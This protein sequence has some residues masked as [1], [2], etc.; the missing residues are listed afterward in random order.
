[1]APS[2]R[3]FGPLARKSKGMEKADVADTGNVVWVDIDD[4]AGQQ[5]IEE[6]LQPL[7]LRPSLVL[8][9]GQKGYWAYFKLDRLIPTQEIETLNQRLALAVGGD[10]AW[11]SNRI[12]RMPYSVHPATGAVA[13]L[14]DWTGSLYSPMAL[15]VLP[16][17]PLP[18]VGRPG[19]EAQEPIEP[20]DLDSTA[21]PLPKLSAPLWAYIRA[22]P[23]RKQGWDRSEVEQSIFYALVQQE[24][25]DKQIVA[26]ANA[27]RLP[28]HMEERA[29]KRRKG[30]WTLWSIRRARLKARQESQS[31]SSLIDRED[32]ERLVCK[33]TCTQK[34]QLDRRE[35]LSLIDGQTTD[36]LISI[37]VERFGASRRTVFYALKQLREAGYI[38]RTAGKRHVRTEK[39]E[40]AVARKLRSAMLLPRIHPQAG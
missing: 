27:Y 33:K 38:A 28:R 4:L 21:F 6:A 5:R 24:W 17:L 26:F 3:F 11:N 19:E 12:A 34:R 14:V 32:I 7:G 18:P 25:S 37:V 8:F 13:R 9:S 22:S 31:A 20:S 10:S 40:R 23:R 29:N 35:L 39:G 16:E 36:G 15:D 1:M 30:D 2:M